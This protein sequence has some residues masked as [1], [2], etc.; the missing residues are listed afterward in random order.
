MATAASTQEHPLMVALREIE[1]GIGAARDT[2]A[3]VTDPGVLGD[4]VCELVGLGT[5]LDSLR[6]QL[7]SQAA[8]NGV[9]QTTGHRTMGQYVAALT[10]NAAAV[11]SMDCRLGQWLRDFPCSRPRLNPGQ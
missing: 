7:L 5:E 4:A 11:I 9:A 3:F 2:M 10:N 1:K 8:A 6:L